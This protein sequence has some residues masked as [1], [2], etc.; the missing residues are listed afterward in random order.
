MSFMNVELINFYID[1][2]E[3]YPFFSLYNKFSPQ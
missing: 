2:F 1:A 3:C